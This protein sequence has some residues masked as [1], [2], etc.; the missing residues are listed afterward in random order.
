MRKGQRDVVK[1]GD[2]LE[3]LLAVWHAL[4]FGPDSME[5]CPLSGSEQFHVLPER[6]HCSGLGPPPLLRTH[7]HTQCNI[8]APANEVPTAT[9]TTHRKPGSPANQ[10]HNCQRTESPASAKRVKLPAP[11]FTSVRVKK[12]LYQQWSRKPSCSLISGMKRIF[13][14]SAGPFR[15]L[16]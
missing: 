1:A 2:S 16:R 4:T 7:T 9:T 11:K 8:A 15:L 13:V 14:L 10:D 5:V 6:K 3:S 12:N